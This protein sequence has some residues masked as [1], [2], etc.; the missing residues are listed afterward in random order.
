LLGWLRRLHAGSI[1]RNQRQHGAG[2]LGAWLEVLAVIMGNDGRTWIDR[3]REGLVRRRDKIRRDLEGP[4]SS[5]V[6]VNTS[7]LQAR[8]DRRAR[9]ADELDEIETHLADL[10]VD[11]RNIGSMEGR[12]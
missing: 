2:E 1:A 11:E 5:G 3:Q 6:P 12:E 9:I 8:R 4:A 7:E 10:N